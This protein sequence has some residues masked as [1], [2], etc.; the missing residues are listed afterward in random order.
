MAD[1]VDSKST[2][3]NIVGV[4]VPSR[5]E[6]RHQKTLENHISKVFLP[7]IKFYHFSFP[8]NC[9]PHLFVFPIA[10]KCMYADK[11]Q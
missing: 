5:A 8:L 2:D 4:Q 6:I 9:T 1:A 3:S 7:K 10:S 11:K